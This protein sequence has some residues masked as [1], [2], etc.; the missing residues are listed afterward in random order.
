MADLHKIVGGTKFGVYQED[1]RSSNED[2]MR[3][4][5]KVV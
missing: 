3:E 1:D 2:M 5:M 4:L